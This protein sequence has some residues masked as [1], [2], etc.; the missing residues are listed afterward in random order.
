MAYKITIKKRGADAGQFTVESLDS[1]SCTA[2]H[3]ITQNVN[4]ISSTHIDHGDDTPV[5]DTVNVVE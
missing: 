5:Y 4:I 3:D 1:T 2:V